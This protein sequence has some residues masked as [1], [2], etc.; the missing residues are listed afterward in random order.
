MDKQFA[1]VSPVISE[2]RQLVALNALLVLN[3]HKMRHARTKNAEILAQEHAES[4]PN[5]PLSIIIP[6][7]VVYH[8]IPAIRSLDVNQ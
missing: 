1:H 4:V 3:V 5:V 7:V 6:F 2:V 8:A